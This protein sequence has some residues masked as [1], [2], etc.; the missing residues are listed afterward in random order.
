MS[1]YSQSNRSPYHLH[2]RQRNT[3]V[4]ST[5]AIA[6]YVIFAA[7]ALHEHPECEQK[8]KDE[9]D[10]AK[11]FT[12]EVRRF[13]PFSPTAVART[14]QSFEWQE[15]HFPEGVK[16]LLDLY[17]TDHDPRL[18]EHP[19]EFRPERFRQWNESSF[20]FIPQGSG[21]H[22]I[23]HRCAGEWITIRL[24]EMTLD[25][26]VNSINYDVPEQDLEVSLRGFQR[27]PKAVL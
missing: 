24:M 10:Y 18:W 12:Q 16:V 3:I 9:A 26:L 7:L 1:P 13:Y 5:Y 25:F 8:L 27:C 20:N 23:N 21:D 4:P 15:Y 19:E 17:S 14:C 22:Y 11:L 6:R 2:H